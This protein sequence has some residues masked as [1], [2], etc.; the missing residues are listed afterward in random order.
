MRTEVDVRA[1]LERQ[2]RRELDDIA[3]EWL[4]S[5][6]YVQEVLE[7]EE[8]VDALAQRT[9]ELEAAF[10]SDRE[11]RRRPPP[12]PRTSERMTEPTAQPLSEASSLYEDALSH[13]VADLASEDREVVAFRRAAGI[14]GALLTWREVPAWVEARAAE[15]GTNTLW[16]TVAVDDIPPSGIVTGRAESSSARLLHYFGPDDTW[17]RTVPTRAGHPLE[18]LRV[19]AAGLKAAHAWTEAQA[20]VFVLTG[21]AP[22]LALLRTT[23]GGTSIRHRTWCAWSERIVLDVHPAL[24]PD[25]LAN[26]YRTARRTYEQRRSRGRH[27]V[28]T[29]SPKHLR[30]ARFRV[31]QPAGKPWRDL[32]AAWNNSSPAGERYAQ[33]S[34]FRRDAGLAVT[35]LLYRGLPTRSGGKA[36][37]RER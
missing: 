24:P 14:D 15:Q 20:A 6:R 26:H 36:S 2:L 18:R 25:E 28:R 4:V 22:T 23:T 7:Q 10:S 30:L 17:Q 9:R 3:W 11:R 19:L 12:P 31:T 34:N 1:E 27:L 32:M 21:I 35:R 16:V 33:E 37:R 29:Q 13:A 5:H 8:T